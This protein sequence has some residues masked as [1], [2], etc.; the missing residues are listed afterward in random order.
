[1]K[2]GQ[3][4]TCQVF[5][6]GLPLEPD[7]EYTVKTYEAEHFEGD[8]KDMQG[9]PAVTLVEVPGLFWAGRFKI[10]EQH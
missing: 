5:E 2:P 3:K 7:T 8:R 10:A 1:M 4:V 9:E 6:P